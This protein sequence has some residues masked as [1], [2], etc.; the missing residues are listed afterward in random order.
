MGGQ[1]L[2][3]KCG[4]PASQE[5]GDEF[6]DVP[7]R[8]HG[9]FQREEI[10]AALDYASLSRKPTSVMQGV[11][12]VEA[13][14]VDVLFVT[15][16]K[17]EAEF[18][19]TTTYR[20]Y[21]INATTFHWESQSTTS[22]ASRTGQRYVTSASRVLLFVREQQKNDFGTSPYLNLGRVRCESHRGER[23]IAITWTLDTPMPSEFLTSASLIEL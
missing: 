10:L 14:D 7:L 4:T 3:E 1:T 17:S 19:P 12:Y 16:R 21:P 23:P 8:V 15:L 5:L 13:L 22:L 9:R 11:A 20:D 6:P 18:S 2:T